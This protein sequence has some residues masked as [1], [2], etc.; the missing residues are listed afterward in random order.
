ML[1]Y[2]GLRHWLTIDDIEKKTGPNGMIR[3]RVKTIG[4]ESCQPKTKVNRAVPISRTLRT[5]LDRHRPAAS[6]HG[7]YLPSPEGNR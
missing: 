1:N 5:Y 7:W 4:G 2:A 6:D 3:D